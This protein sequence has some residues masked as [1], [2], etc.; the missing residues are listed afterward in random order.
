MVTVSLGSEVSGISKASGGRL[1]RRLTLTVVDAMLAR[2]WGGT[3][4]MLGKGYGGG[5]RTYH[6]LPVPSP[7]FPLMCY[8]WTQGPV[9]TGSDFTGCLGLR[10]SICKHAGGSPLP[11]SSPTTPQSQ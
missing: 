1:S 8:P 7:V 9:V 4:G 3:E 10:I 5:G 11:P 2:D 6:I